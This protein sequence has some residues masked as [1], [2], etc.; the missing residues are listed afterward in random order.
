MGEYRGI[1]ESELLKELEEC[2]DDFRAAIQ[3]FGVYGDLSDELKD[4]SKTKASETRVKMVKENIRQYLEA[5]LGMIEAGAKYISLY[6]ICKKRLPDSEVF[7]NPIIS[8]K[9]G[10]MENLLKKSK[11]ELI[12]IMVS[13]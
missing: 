7:N 13:G 9:I 12:R 3:K 1:T 10:Y 6:H 11:K 5:E 2:G 8:N 4:F